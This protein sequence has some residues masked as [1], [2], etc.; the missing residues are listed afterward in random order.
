M[1]RKLEKNESWLGRKLPVKT[2]GGE[3]ILMRPPWR[4]IE[5][6]PNMSH[7]KDIRTSEN[8]ESR[9]IDNQT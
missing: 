2:F 7:H 9:Y 4:E 5:F 1:L 8:V 3:R 6:P